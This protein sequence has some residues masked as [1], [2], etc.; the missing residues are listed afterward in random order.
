M[1]LLTKE[2][3]IK[4]H[5]K[6]KYYESLGYKIPL[7][8]TKDGM[9]MLKDTEIV[10]NV[11]DLPKTSTYKVKVKCNH[12]GKEYELSYR[13]Y[14]RY[15]HEGDVSYCQQCHSKALISGENCY[16]WNP[17]LTDEE[18]EIQRNT[19]ERNE[20][21]KRVMARDNYTCQCCNKPLNHDGVVH[22][23]DGWDNFKEQRY[24]DTNGIT[25]CETCHKNFHSKYGYGGNTKEQFEEWIGQA[26]EL[27]KYEDELPTARK[28]YCIEE[29]K[30]YDSYK[31]VM[32]EFNIKNRSSI[33]N[34]CNHRAKT[35]YK[36]HLLWLDE[37]ILNGCIM[38]NT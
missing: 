27:L 25:L 11:K 30:I 21:V 2:V 17:N 13:N 24:D 34:V 36:K 18:R 33:Y 38:T 3:K 16:N 31:D 35:I 29:D 5:N 7:R 19:K 23:L 15:V 20:F 32:K 12:C 8:K 4:V 9:K 22:H 26:I 37:A 6:K 10:V 1:T 28:I 14:L